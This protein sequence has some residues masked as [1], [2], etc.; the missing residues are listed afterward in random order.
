MASLCERNKD[1]ENR[2]IIPSSNSAVQLPFLAVNTNKKTHIN[3][4][5]SNDK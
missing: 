2:G 4:S 1:L 5:I 3:C